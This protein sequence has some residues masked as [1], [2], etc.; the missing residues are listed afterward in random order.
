MDTLEVDL[1][2]QG[3]IVAGLLC[4]GLLGSRFGRGGLHGRIILVG[5]VVHVVRRLAVRLQ[6]RGLGEVHHVDVPVASP[7][8]VEGEHR[9]VGGPVSPSVVSRVHGDVHGRRRAVGGHNPHVVVV[10]LIGSGVG[11][12][13]AIGRP[14]HLRLS[15]ALQQGELLPRLQVPD[16]EVPETAC[17]GE[18]LAVRRGVEGELG[19]R[20]V[21]HLL[22]DHLQRPTQV[23][24]GLRLLRPVDVHAAPVVSDE[25][26][27]V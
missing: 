25:V 18:L 16:D 5:E 1:D 9:A 11:D 7:I 15:P 21:G 13:A 8:G 12:P 20:G 22:D 3:V 4:L 24:L 17:V 14:R 19:L 23:R 2:D 10:L 26:H 27:P 6:G